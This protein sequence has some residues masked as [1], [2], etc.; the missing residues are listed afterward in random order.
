M[1]ENRGN[2]DLSRPTAN[3]PEAWLL[4]GVGLIWLV[5]GV[6]EGGIGMILALLPG[7]LLLATGTGELLFRG[8]R[9]ILQFASLGAA[10]GVAVGAIELLFMGFGAAV[11]LEL[12][13]AAAFV[14]AGRAA[15]RSV[16]RYAGVP[17]P[18]DGLVLAAKVALDEAVLST[19]A[20]T[21]SVPTPERAS[22]I[23][24]E[25]DDALSLFGDQGWLE[26]PEN[27]HRVPLPLEAPRLEAARSR[28]IAFEH[29]TFE[30][31]YEP[32]AEEPGR[33][34][35]LGYTA[36]RTAHAWVM[37]HAGPPRPWLVC[38]P[39]YRMGSPLTDLA[40]FDP[41]YYHHRLG[42]N[43]VFPVVPLHGQRKFGRRSG[44]GFLSG[45]ALDTVHAEAQTMWDVRRLLS[46][47]RSQD[48]PAVGAMGL[49]LGGYHTA[50][51]A[52]L[53]PGLTCAI[54]GVPATDLCQLLFQLGADGQRRVFEEAG[55]SVEGVQQLF[56]IVSPL[57]L[58]PRVAPEG[59]AIFGGIVDRLVTPDQVCRLYTHWGEPRIAWYPGGHMTF[60]RDPAV[61]ECIRSTLTGTGLAA[62]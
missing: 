5:A 37:R 18:H 12:V 25:I 38:I 54:A 9:R 10:L 61:K 46:W 1:N 14:A 48:A 55:V 19:M 47:V 60:S 45:N 43:L 4:S 20:L 23:G 30:S 15:L 49:S 34:R 2:E 40:V 6:D 33:E 24:A 27:Y 17:E 3:A 8:D 51:L 26:K 11:A 22:R 56:R 41:R 21:S 62:A 52:C 35:W 44:D 57:V 53:E 31:E 58:E 50:L 16:P 39:G 42:L 7:G 29:L 28:G 13:S 59:R 36:N 32:F